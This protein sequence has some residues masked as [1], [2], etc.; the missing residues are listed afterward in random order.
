MLNHEPKPEDKKR[1]TG[2]LLA[3][4]LKS[5]AFKYSIRRIL[6]SVVT[7]LA[8]I[9]ITFFA[10]HAIPGGPFQAEKSLSHRISPEFD[11]NSLP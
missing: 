6:L 2:K 9:T 7:V 3:D 8:V 1:H 5:D 10:M 11:G 4:I